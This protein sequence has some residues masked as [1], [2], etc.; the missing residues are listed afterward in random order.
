MMKGRSREAA[1][2]HPERT[3]AADTRET[4]TSTNK[5]STAASDDGLNG[6]DFG[7]HWFTQG[8]LDANVIFRHRRRHHRF[9]AHITALFIAFCWVSDLC[10]I[11]FSAIDAVD[12]TLVL[13]TALR[14]FVP[15]LSTGV[16]GFAWSTGARISIQSR[17]H[18]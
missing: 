15:F 3:A 2:A 8:F 7:R 12:T 16:I 6:L 4:W 10:A 5:A 14:V 1:A 17:R 9:Y 13:V 18:H 11:N